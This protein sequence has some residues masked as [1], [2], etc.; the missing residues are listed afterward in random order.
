VQFLGGRGDGEQRD[1]PTR[2]RGGPE[3]YDPG[4]YSGP[5]DDEPPF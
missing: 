3:P 2:G 4:D 1:T 5:E